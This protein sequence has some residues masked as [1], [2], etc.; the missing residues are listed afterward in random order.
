MVLVCVRLCEAP[1]GRF[2]HLDILQPLGL[3]RSTV[4]MLLARWL[5]CRR[6][7]DL[8][9]EG[10]GHI[11]QVLPSHTPPQVE[12]EC[13]NPS[14]GVQAVPAKVVGELVGRLS[15]LVDSGR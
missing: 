4:W 9:D 13:L 14:V 8:G 11:E 10:E 5:A 1:A 15:P 7:V 2:N 6:G 12:L 3:E